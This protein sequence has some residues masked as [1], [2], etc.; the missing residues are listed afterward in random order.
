MLGLVVIAVVVGLSAG[1]VALFFGSSILT[2][3]GL[4][5]L[6]GWLFIL[7]AIIV[8]PAVKALKGRIRKHDPAHSG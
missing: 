8:L 5:V 1:A 7:A 2:A 3:L 6:S 4:Y